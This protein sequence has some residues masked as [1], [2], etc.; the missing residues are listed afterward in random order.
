M[1]CC[2]KNT[3]GHL[4]KS[5]QADGGSRSQAP[6]RDHSVPEAHKQSPVPHAWQPPGMQTATSMCTPRY[7]H[8]LHS[9]VMA[10]HMGRPHKKLVYCPTICQGFRLHQTPKHWV[11]SHPHLVPSSV[12]SSPS[13]PS[14]WWAEPILMAPAKSLNT[15]LP[16]R[17]EKGASASE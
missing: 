16:P 10:G 17:T 5:T 11:K 8:C 13:C 12:P 7:Q 15:F 6:L 2:T 4:P 9:P 1:K 3:D 14:S